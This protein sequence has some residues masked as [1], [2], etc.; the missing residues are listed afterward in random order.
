MY[1]TYDR[2]PEGDLVRVKGYDCDRLILEPR[3]RIEVR[4]PVSE[5]YLQFW[6]DELPDGRVPQ[7]P[8]AE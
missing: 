5:V 4:V 8:R 7:W 3:Q 6:L 1:D 2:M